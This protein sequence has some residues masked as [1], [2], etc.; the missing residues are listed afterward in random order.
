[1]SPKT[2]QALQ[3]IL[4]LG[5]IASP[6]HPRYSGLSSFSYNY[7]QS[8]ANHLHEKQKFGLAGGVSA[9]CDCRVT[10]LAEPTFLHINTW[11]CTAGSTRSQ[12]DNHK[13][14]L[15]PTG[16][17]FFSYKRSLKLTLV[18]SVTPLFR[19]TFPIKMGRQTVVTHI[20]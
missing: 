6:D 14:L 18:G 9:F 15:A 13:A 4:V 8:M 5:S 2:L 19:S 11:A 7:L 12:R 3:R 20:T 10:Q 17:K 16:V 1:M